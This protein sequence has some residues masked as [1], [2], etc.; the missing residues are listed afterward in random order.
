MDG[1]TTADSKMRTVSDTL[2]LR[3]ID[4]TGMSSA[5]PVRSA[6]EVLEYRVYKRR[7]IG[8]AQLVLLNV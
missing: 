8:L 7:F 3:G 2:E 4:T 5:S 1:S 6:D